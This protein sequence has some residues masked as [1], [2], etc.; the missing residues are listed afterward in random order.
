MNKIILNSEKCYKGSKTR[1]HDSVRGVLPLRL[2]V[3]EDLLERVTLELILELE[4]VWCDE[5]WVEH[6]KANALRW[7]K[8]EQGPLQR[9]ASSRTTRLVWLEYSEKVGEWCVLELKTWAGAS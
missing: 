5:I 9:R 4:T 6:S 8:E 3:K 2:V 7:H 1:S